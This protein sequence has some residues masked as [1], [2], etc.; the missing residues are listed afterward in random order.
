MCPAFIEIPYLIEIECLFKIYSSPIIIPP[1][2]MP[3][4]IQFLS[5]RSFVHPS[6]SWNLPQ[7]SPPSWVKV[8][9][10]GYISESIFGPWVPWKV[11][12]NAMSFG[13]RWGWRSKSRT[14]L[15]SVFLPFLWKQLAQIVGQT[16]LSIVTLT[17][18]SWSEGQHDL[19]FR[20]QW[21]CLISWKTNVWTS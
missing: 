13:P 18:R 6:R 9:Q 4:G 8:F 2:F 19:Y 7:S 16:L 5:F 21:F 1:A 17:C 11:C 10:M 3:R 15:K 12:F 20:V 14:P